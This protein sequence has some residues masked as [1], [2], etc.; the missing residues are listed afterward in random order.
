MRVLILKN[1]IAE[2][3][4][5]VERATSQSGSLAALKNFHI[6]TVGGKV[7]ITATNLELAVRATVSG[8]VMESGSCSVPA[9]V[10]APMFKNIPAERI[11]LEWKDRVLIIR[12]D[13]YEARVPGS[14]PKEFPIIPTVSEG[15]P[16]ITLPVGLYRD[17]F[18]SVVAAAQ[19]S[20]IRPE[21]SGV[22]CKFDGDSLVFAA[23][24]SFRLSEWRMGNE[25]F[26]AQGEAS[27]IIPLRASEESLR[28]FSDRDEELS[29][30]AD[31]G[32]VFFGTPT[33][34]LVSRLVDGVF[35]DYHAIVP[36]KTKSEISVSRAEFI[37]GIR[38]VSALAGKGNDITVR[39]R[40]GER[41]L[42]L[43]AGDGG[44][45]EGEY[46]LSGKT[47]GEPFSVVFNWKYLLDGLRVFKGSEVSLGINDAGPALLMSHE[48]PNLRYVVMP[49]RA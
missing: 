46:A 13:N 16:S 28:V 47:K 18:E 41:V 22:Y 20:E 31:Q 6:A 8:K 29:I 36:H 45:G 34:N 49:I 25:K 15:V 9:S 12:S 17:S 14:D 35:P 11:T 3:V 43:M 5:S 38:L 40:E 32:Q 30:A 23:T 42:E 37:S 4:S 24:D 44:L 10:V 39:V 21:I 48:D 27:I 1:N 19:Y 33:K 7:V 26:S 2:A